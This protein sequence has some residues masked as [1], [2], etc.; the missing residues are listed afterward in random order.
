MIDSI[1]SVLITD[2][3]PIGVMDDPEWP[4]DEYDGYI[5]D[6]YE[7]IRRGEPAEFIARHLCLI[8]DKKMG[9]GSLPVSARI[10]VAEKLKALAPSFSNGSNL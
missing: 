6:L 1:R 10:S 8:E 3:D 4:R 7:F 2:W 9:L 5:G